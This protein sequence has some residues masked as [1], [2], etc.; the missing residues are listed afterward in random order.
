MKNLMTTFQLNIA[1]VKFDRISPIIPSISEGNKSVCLSWS[2]GG[3]GLPT[4]LCKKKIS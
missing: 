1:Q 4:S 2:L 3:F